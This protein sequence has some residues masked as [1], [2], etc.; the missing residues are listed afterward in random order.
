MRTHILISF[1][2]GHGDRIRLDREKREH[3]DDV[4]SCD[5]GGED[6]VG[7]QRAEEGD[8]MLLQPMPRLALDQHCKWAAGEWGADIVEVFA[9]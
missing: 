8:R 2:R 9:R 1:R 4:E 6:E 3:D 7:L 5:E